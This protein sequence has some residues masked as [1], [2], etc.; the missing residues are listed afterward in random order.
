MRKTAPMGRRDSPE[1]KQRHATDIARRLTSLGG[2]EGLLWLEP[3]RLWLLG[4]ISSPPHDP[5]GLARLLLDERLPAR[6]RFAQL[7]GARRQLL[8]DVSALS[9]WARDIA[10]LQS[11][12]DLE[13]LVEEGIRPLRRYRGTDLCARIVEA[14]RLLER[15]GLLVPALGAAARCQEAEP[16]AEVPLDVLVRAL[17][18]R[19]Y[20]LGNWT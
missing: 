9:G 5:L 1:R 7:L 15:L 2:M 18:L 17:P 12:R 20:A 14:G 4:P 3:G 16:D 11:R 6:V 19:L 8:V 13:A 10:E